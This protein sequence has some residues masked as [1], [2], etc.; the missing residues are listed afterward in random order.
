[1]KFSNSAL[2]FVSAAFLL[3]FTAQGEEATPSAWMPDPAIISFHAASAK[4][5]TGETGQHIT[6][7]NPSRLATVSARIHLQNGRSFGVF[8]ISELPAAWNSCN[9]MK[10]ENGWF[11]SDGIN[12]VL[13]FDAGPSDH[14]FLSTA[15]LLTQTKTVEKTT[16]GDEGTL[17]LMLTEAS[18]ND[19]SLTFKVDGE[20][21]DGDYTNLEITTECAICNVC[22]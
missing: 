15:P 11:H 22:G 20:V 3:T 2:I 10:L 14:G 4:V 19:E 13:T 16:G 21:A 5:S 6:L 18:L 8:P 9:A 7:S 1:M 12:S 17:Y